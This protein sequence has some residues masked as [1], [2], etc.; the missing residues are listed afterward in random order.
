[1]FSNNLLALSAQI[2]KELLASHQTLAVAESCT[3]GLIGHILTAVPGSSDYFIG[4]IIAY[5]NAVKVNL[6]RVDPAVLLQEGAVSAA[7]VAQMASGIAHLMG[8]DWGVAISGIA[9]PGGGTPEKPVGLVWIGLA[10]KKSEALARKFYF[11]GDRREI[12]EA[13]AQ[14]ALT[15][16]LEDLQGKRQV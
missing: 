12:K 9:G 16:L 7:V 2:G 5:S 6:L 10:T 4:G 15:L 13:A 1:M 11:N 14:M 3:G 8:S